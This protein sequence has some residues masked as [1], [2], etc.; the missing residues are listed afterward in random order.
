MRRAG[1][2]RNAAGAD[3]AALE[4]DHIYDMWHLVSC[5]NMPIES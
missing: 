2:A 5:P 4:C 1:K 3:A